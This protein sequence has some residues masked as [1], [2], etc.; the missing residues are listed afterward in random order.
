M[1]CFHASCKVFVVIRL[2]DGRYCESYKVERRN[3]NR[4]S[5]RLANIVGV[6]NFKIS[7]INKGSTILDIRNT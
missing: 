5:L 7:N 1:L 6:I 2:L 3:R 4:T